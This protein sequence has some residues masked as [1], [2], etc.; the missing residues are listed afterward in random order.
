[1]HRGSSEGSLL[2][3][4]SSMEPAAAYFAG[5]DLGEM[6][7]SL[8][9]HRFCD[10]TRIDN[11]GGFGVRHSGARLR[12]VDTITRVRVALGC[13]GAA[14]VEVLGTHR[15]RCALENFL[16]LFKEFMRLTNQKLIGIGNAMLTHQTVLCHDCVK[17]FN[18]SSIFASGRT[19]NL[20]ESPD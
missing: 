2:G 1:M 15:S 8:S 14:S 3:E 11:L 18:L 16:N 6:G 10:G 12:T 4:A 7:V 17:L 13:R 5:F 19:N 20:M 9:G